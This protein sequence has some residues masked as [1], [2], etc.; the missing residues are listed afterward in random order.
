MGRTIGIGHQN[1]EDIRIKNNFY[2]DKTH[3]IKDT[4]YEY[5]RAVFLG[6][7]CGKAGFV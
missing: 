3:F 7:I 6:Q 5:V 4:E 2:V 1:F